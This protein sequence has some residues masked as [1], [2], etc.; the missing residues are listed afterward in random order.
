MSHLCLI[1]TA[2]FLLQVWT[3]DSRDLP[4]YPFR[5]HPHTQAATILGFP[6]TGL[7][8]RPGEGESELTVLTGNT[9]RSTLRASEDLTSRQGRERRERGGRKKGSVGEGG[10]GGGWGREAALE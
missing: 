2:I 3:V 8:T 1:I 10:D 4:Q 7:P 9:S 5:E 6:N